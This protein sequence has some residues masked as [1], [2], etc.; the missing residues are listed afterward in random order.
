MGGGG[1]DGSPLRLAARLEPLLLPPAPPCSAVGLS[2]LSKP[3]WVPDLGLAKRA[4]VL[5][6]FFGISEPGS[7]L[8]HEVRRP[9][10]KIGWLER[11]P[12]GAEGPVGG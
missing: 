4:A 9:C 1:R 5:D 10:G 2:K 12:P 7:P 11:T 8:R 3:K 6:V